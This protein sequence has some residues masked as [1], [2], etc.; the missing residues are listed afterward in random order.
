VAQ[1]DGVTSA[2]GEATL[3]REKGGDDVSRVDANLTGS[4]NKE[5]LHD[6]FSCYK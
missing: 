4:K 1:H 5:N 3:E 2:G 6:R